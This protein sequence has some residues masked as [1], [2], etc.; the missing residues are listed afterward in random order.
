MKS[1]LKNFVLAFLVLLPVVFAQAE[2]ISRGL[3]RALMGPLPQAC[4]F[5]LNSSDCIACLG[6]VKILPFIFFFGLA[7]FAMVFVVVRII[8]GVPKEGLN[9]KKL[10]PSFYYAIILISLAL[11]LLTL[12]FRDFSMLFISIGQLHRVLIVAFSIVVVVTFLY[13]IQPL[14]PM[15]GLAVILFSI[16]IVWTLYNTLTQSGDFSLLKPTFEIANSPCFLTD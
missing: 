3:L 9:I 14:H 2:T 4:S 8:G 15:L 5:S 13:T 16:G 1:V 6:T 10:T 12:H 7:Y 11:A